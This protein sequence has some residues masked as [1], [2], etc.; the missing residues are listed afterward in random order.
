MI[1]SEH[2]RDEGYIGKPI[3][4][5]REI[6]QMFE[7]NIEEYCYLVDIWATTTLRIYLKMA[8]WQTPISYAS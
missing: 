6:A 4:E 5:T 8:D 2:S 1:E 3:P 7:G